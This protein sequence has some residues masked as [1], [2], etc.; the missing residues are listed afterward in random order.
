MHEEIKKAAVKN[1]DK[2]GEDTQILSNITDNEPTVALGVE[3]FPNFSCS[4]SCVYN[5]LELAIN[6]AVK[7]L[8]FIILIFER[9]ND[10][11]T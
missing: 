3:L 2:V 5:F 10:I 6:D 7:F 11:R 9:I 1:N 8:E 4:V